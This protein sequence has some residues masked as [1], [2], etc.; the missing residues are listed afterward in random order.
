MKPKAFTKTAV[1]ALRLPP[2]KNDHIYWDPEL[3]GFGVRL[4]GEHRR[5][6]VQYRVGTQQR[7]ESFD[8]RQISLDDARKIARQRFAQAH[9]G[10]DPAA[11]RVKAK[12][13]AEAAK[14]TLGNVADRYLAARA[15]VLRPATMR[16][17]RWH[18]NTLWA[19]LHGKPIAGIRRPDVAARLAEIAR[20]NGRTSSALARRTLS[21]CF[22]WCI[23]EGLAEVNPIAG[24]NDPGR[25]QQ[26]RDRVLS[27]AELSAV[28][29]AAEPD[30]LNDFGT[31]ARLLILTG[32][33]RQE[34]GSLRWD[35]ID[36]AT[37]LLAIPAARAKNRERFEIT[38]PEP[39]LAILRAVPRR[40]G[41]PS[42]F[43]T[44]RCGYSAWSYAFNALSLR[45]AEAQGRPLPPWR[46]HDVRRTVRTG[47]GRLG[48]RPD[49]AERV[50]GHAKGGVEAIYDRHRYEP[51]IRAA[52]A[53]W[54]AHVHAIV[55]Q[56]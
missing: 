23:R 12:A 28:W 53:A 24:T 19:P 8:P 46:L 27:D 22:A 47:L 45:I 2:G 7:R 31:I 44:V 18:L 9:L 5:W 20:D 4:R 3:P 35:E 15:P 34:I 11:D 38:L 17:A 25:D 21:A 56:K 10:Q 14:L 48:V 37:G 33:R 30:V 6:I 13:E 36:L 54:A 1:D 42:V 52:L 43:G 32:M 55:S 40:E 41:N 51:E 39:A 26:A 29:R 50:I 49:V 16:A